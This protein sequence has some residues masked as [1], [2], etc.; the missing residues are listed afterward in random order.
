MKNLYKSVLL[1]LF[2]TGSLTPFAQVPVYSS[3]ASAPAVLFLDFDGHNVSGT[4]WNYNGPIV[5]APAGL[6]TDQITEI[7]NRIAEDYRPFNIN[8][9]TDQSKY[10]AAAANR[11]MRVI[12]TT[13]YEWYGSSAGGVAYTGSFTWGDNTPCFIFTSLLGYNAKYLAEAG[14]H[15]AGHTFGLRHQASYDANCNLLNSYN[16]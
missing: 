11:R 8:V 10:T 5:A 6:N 15:E 7:Y 16:Y 9:T 13:T 2:L 12:F 4:S 14:A 1:A 3:T